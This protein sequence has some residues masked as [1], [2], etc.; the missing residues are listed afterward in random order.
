VGLRVYDSREFEER[1][2]FNITM[3][4]VGLILFGLLLA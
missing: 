2:G 3:G 1:R 4:R